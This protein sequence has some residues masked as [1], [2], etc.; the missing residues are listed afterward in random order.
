M[1]YTSPT[2]LEVGVILTGGIIA[3][4][5]LCL[6]SAPLIGPMLTSIHDAIGAWLFVREV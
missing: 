5:L 4:F 6:W 1:Y 3:L 2:L